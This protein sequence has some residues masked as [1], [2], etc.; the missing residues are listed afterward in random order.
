MTNHR[1]RARFDGDCS[2]RAGVGLDRAVEAL[3][4]LRDSFP[5]GREHPTP[6]GS[7]AIDIEQRTVG[8]LYGWR[9]GSVEAV[10]S[11]T[12]DALGR[13]RRSSPTL[14]RDRS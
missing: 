5:A 4:R 3:R 10:R 14:G 2:A 13:S 8:Y 11:D 9:T 6:M 1:A 7:S 12:S